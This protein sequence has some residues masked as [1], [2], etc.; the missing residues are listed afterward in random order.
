MIALLRHPLGGDAPLR[1][2]LAYLLIHYSSPVVLLTPEQPLQ[3][4]LPGI[5]GVQPVMDQLVAQ[6]VEVELLRLLQHPLGQGRDLVEVDLSNKGPE[7]Q[8]VGRQVVL[9]DLRY[10]P[11]P[12]Q[13]SV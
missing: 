4:G 3:V 12:G 11:A 8:I 1:Q 5:P 9:A 7:G 13:Q 2:R 6:C 10:L